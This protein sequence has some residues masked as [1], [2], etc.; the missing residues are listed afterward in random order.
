[1]TPNKQWPP[2]AKAP[3]PQAEKLSVP[4]FTL[5]QVAPGSS[6]P[7][8]SSNSSCS[9]VRKPFALSDDLVVFTRRAA[10]RM[11]VVPQGHV[12]FFHE[13]QQRLQYQFCCFPVFKKGEI[14]SRRVA[15]LFSCSQNQQQ[16]M[17]TVEIYLAGSDRS[18]ILFHNGQPDASGKPKSMILCWARE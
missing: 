3:A 8:A 9:T 13:H 11:H 12:W 10:A 2:E 17:M 15:A 7:S 16:M 4:S 6:T 14:I 5:P 1:M 18:S